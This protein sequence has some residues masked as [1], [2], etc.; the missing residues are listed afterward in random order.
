MLSQ[1][2]EWPEYGCIYWYLNTV[3]D[4]V[5]ERWGYGYIHHSAEKGL[6]KIGNCFRTKKEAIKARDKI[7]K[8]LKQIN[9]Y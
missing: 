8:L 1:P 6:R 3:L 4:V 9:D 2:A 5:V 7:K